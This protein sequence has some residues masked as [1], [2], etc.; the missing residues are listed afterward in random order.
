MTM[1]DCYCGE[2]SD[3]VGMRRRL[4]LE[5]LFFGSFSGSKLQQG[6]PRE[7]FKDQLE[8]QLNPAE[9]PNQLILSDMK[10][11]LVISLDEKTLH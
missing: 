10:K 6:L 7:S 9:V 5:L 1:A 11:V 2:P 8:D 4:W 3:G